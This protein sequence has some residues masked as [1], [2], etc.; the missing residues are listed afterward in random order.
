[1]LISGELEDCRRAEHATDV[2]A[3][4]MSGVDG[5]ECHRQVH[6]SCAGLTRNPPGTR[7]YKMT[8]RVFIYAISAAS[9]P[10]CLIALSIDFFRARAHTS[11]AARQNSRDRTLLVR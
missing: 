2:E 6:S 1:M 5:Y 9:P 8:Y 11:T 10:V 3:M 4:T 7:R